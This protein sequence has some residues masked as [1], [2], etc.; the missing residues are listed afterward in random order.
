MLTEQTDDLTAVIITLQETKKKS[1]RDQVFDKHSMKKSM[2]TE[3]ESEPTTDTASKT[4]FKISP[5][6]KGSVFIAFYENR[7][8]IY[9]LSCLPQKE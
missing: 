6:N 1:T 4:L 9:V 5:R 2:V 7:L 3:E 8:H